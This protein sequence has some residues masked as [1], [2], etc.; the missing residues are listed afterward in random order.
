MGRHRPTTAAAPLLLLLLLIPFVLGFPKP[1]RVIEPKCVAWLSR[2]METP[3][4]PHV[5]CHM[6]DMND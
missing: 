3:P 6:V 1:P 5:P 2:S 4:S